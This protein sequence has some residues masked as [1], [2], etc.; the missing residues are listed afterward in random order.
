MVYNKPAI[1]INNQLRQLKARGLSVP[2]HADAKHYL[3]Q[4]GYYRL[5]GYW[6][7]MQHDP[8][9][10]LFRR[11]SSFSEVIERYNFDRELR[12]ICL[13]MIERIEVGLRTHMIY[14]L[15]LAYTPYWF[16]Q[17][18]HA[19][20]QQHWQQ[21]LG[22]MGREVARSGERFI[23]EHR[24][25]YHTDTR[26]PPSWK[27]ME[28]IT[29]GLLS[30]MYR[31]LD[32]ALPEKTE[33]AANL[34]LPDAETLENW[35]H[36][37]ALVRNVSAHHCRLFQ[38]SMEIRPTMPLV[39]TGS[40]IDTQGVSS[41]SIYAHLSCMQYL[42]QTISPNNRFPDRLKQLFLD[43]PSIRFRQ[44]G[45]PANWKTQPLWQ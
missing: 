35:L 37:I 21:N 34:L 31:N 6:W 25:K 45:F 32:D 18:Q 7:T 1:T 38:R 13:N 28:V 3:R 33:I 4:V 2:S 43:Y 30:K 12:L 24:I 27:S 23:K 17:Q 11:G 44:I 5:A 15:S 20:N 14:N 41:K 42:L 40:W 29:L 16:E 26:N 22:K 39:L 8:Q 19:K 10:H 9:R 36:A